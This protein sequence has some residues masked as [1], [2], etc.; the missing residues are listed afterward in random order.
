[1]RPIILLLM[2]GLSL[3]AQSMMHYF[4]TGNAFPVWVKYSVAKTAGNWLV[5]GGNSQAA[6]GEAGCGSAGCK[7]SRRAAPS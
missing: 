2:S 6:S 4:S 1:M 7:A 5:N 3:Q